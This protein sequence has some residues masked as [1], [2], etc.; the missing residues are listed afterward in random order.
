MKKVIE[1]KTTES[2]SQIL[3]FTFVAPGEPIGHGVEGIA[4][5][6]KV[7]CESFL[8]GTA[9][10]NQK[11]TSA[12]TIGRISGRHLFAPFVGSTLS[13]VDALNLGE[14]VRHQLALIVTTQSKPAPPLKV[15][16]SIENG[17]GGRYAKIVSDGSELSVR[18]ISSLNDSD[19]LKASAVEWRE[20]AQRYE[21]MAN[22]AEAAA[23]MLS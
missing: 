17:T 13:K 23:A 6:A 1:Y 3:R 7:V 2:D 14:W 5:V 12:S 18:L 16:V 19:S 8:V 9:G 11:V 20:K 22:K 21:V 10:G 4:D 15:R